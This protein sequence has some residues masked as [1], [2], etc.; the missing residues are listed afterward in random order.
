MI[1]DCSCSLAGTP[2]L[3]FPFSNIMS[4]RDIRVKVPPQTYMILRPNME[5]Y[6]STLFGE[7]AGIGRAHGLLTDHEMCM[8][9]VKNVL[10]TALNLFGHTVAVC[11]LD[12]LNMFLVVLCYCMHMGMLG[13]ILYREDMGGEDMRKR[14]AFAP[15]LNSVQCLVLYETVFDIFTLLS[16]CVQNTDSLFQCKQME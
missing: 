5:T 15:T 3:L 12:L 1:T 14:Y 13:R 9:I 7:L 2:D 4:G 10:L 6:L 16:R 8:L 11:N